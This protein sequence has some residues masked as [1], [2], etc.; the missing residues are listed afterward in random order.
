MNST[1][2]RNIEIRSLRH[3]FTLRGGGA[4]WL[5]KRIPKL[6]L[7]VKVIYMNCGVKNCMNLDYRRYHRSYG[8]NFFAAWNFSGFLFVTGGAKWLRKRI[9]KLWLYVKVIYM[10]CGVKNC[11]NLDYRRYHRSYGRNFFAAWNFSGFL[12]VTA[13]VASITVMIHFHIKTTP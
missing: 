1:P 12:F 4:K 8:R 9:P 7:Y 11:M 13:K 2:K 10:N 5:R 6:W 3:Q